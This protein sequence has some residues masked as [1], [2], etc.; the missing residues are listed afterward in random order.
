MDRSGDFG[1]ARGLPTGA[2]ETR[3]AGRTDAITGSLGNA[4]L[5]EAQID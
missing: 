3:H 2:A 4:C 5:K 1:L